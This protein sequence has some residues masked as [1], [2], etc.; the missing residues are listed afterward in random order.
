MKKQFCLCLLLFVF[1]TIN[2]TAMSQEKKSPSLNHLALYVTNLQKSTWFYK[3]VI[4][5]DSMPEPFH[6]GRHTWF[7]VGEHSQLHIIS[8]ASAPKEHDKDTHVCFSVAHL[9][10]A[11]ARLDKNNIPYENWAGESKKQTRRA[12]GVMQIYLKDPDGYWIEINDD[13]F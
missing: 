7:K 6:D 8:G 9:S 1:I 10:D 4:G 3:D 13:K 2:M 5:L 11:I 12:D